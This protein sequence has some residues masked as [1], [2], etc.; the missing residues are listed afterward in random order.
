MTTPD[1]RASVRSVPFRTVLGEVGLLLVEA[2]RRYLREHPD[3]GGSSPDELTLIE[4]GCQYLRE[5]P[6][7]LR[8]PFRSTPG[9]QHE[10]A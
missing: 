5:H 9:G 6:E 2:G 7:A 3:E 10:R 1:A 4:A 8:A